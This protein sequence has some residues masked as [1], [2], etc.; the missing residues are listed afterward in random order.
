MVRSEV[1]MTPSLC[2]WSRCYSV[3]VD[4]AD[5]MPGIAGGIGGDEDCSQSDHFDRSVAVDAAAAAVAAVGLVGF[6]CCYC[7]GLSRCCCCCWTG[8]W[9]D[10]SPDLVLGFHLKVGPART[11]RHPIA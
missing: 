11:V 5:C 8:D 1:A 10:L 7:C 6:D 9:D 4:S 3:A 2:H